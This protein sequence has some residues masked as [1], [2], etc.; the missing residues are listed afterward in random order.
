M[1]ILES[2][3]SIGA[4]KAPNRI[5]HQPMEC[6]DS[7]KG[8]P[9]ELTINR[10]RKMAA[11][12]A[13]ITIVESTT[14]VASALSRNHQL[15]TD[16]KHRSGINQ[17]TQEFKRVNQETLL[18]YQLTHP[19]AVSDPRFSDVVRV[20]DP[21]D[22]SK[23]VGR[24]LSK[25]EIKDLKEA[26]IKGAEIVHESGADMVDFKLCHAYL[27]CQMLRPANT[28]NDEYGGSLENRMRFTKEVIEGIKE[29]IADPKFKIMVR[30]SV[31]E[32]G[33]R[34]G[35]PE[36]GGIG[37]IG[38]DSTEFDFEEPY[39]MLRMLT[40]Y[41][42]DI[43]DISGGEV[44]PVKKPAPLDINNPQSYASYHLLDYAKRVKSLNLGVPI[45]AS[46]YSLFGQDMAMVGENSILQGYADMMGI[47]RQALVDPDLRRIL[48]GDTNYCKRCMGCIDLLISQM[49]VGCTQYDPV[50]AMLRESARL[51]SDPRRKN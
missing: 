15:I 29:R 42:V 20:Y 4:V 25:G 44:I 7:F 50:Y 3:I 12:K 11:G 8:F 26:F 5:V 23:W 13:G 14:V 16:E 18:C 33:M 45:V 38:P 27:G 31:Y 51:N 17:L 34:P 2:P 28:R 6:N 49:P 9:S 47:G 19:G 22:S 32:G 24:L 21:Q 43:L 10:Y 30:F 39:E 36:V 35:T 40:K 41:G 48:K 37:A 46:G 1:S